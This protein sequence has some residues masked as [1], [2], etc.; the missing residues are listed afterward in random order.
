MTFSP[1][2][3]IFLESVLLLCSLHIFHPRYK[4]DV[5]YW[6]IHPP[7]K[8]CIIAFAVGCMNPYPKHWVKG[9]RHSKANV[10]RTH[11]C[12]HEIKIASKTWDQNFAHRKTR[13]L[14]SLGNN[15]LATLFRARY[16]GR[17]LQR[18]WTESKKLKKK[19]EKRWCT[20]F[21]NS[22]LIILSFFSYKTKRH[23]NFRRECNWR[24][25]GLELWNIATAQKC[26]MNDRI[27]LRQDESPIVH[28]LGFYQKK[29]RLSQC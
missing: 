3:E 12:K 6:H 17:F 19:L 7:M 18:L 22:A 16:S 1:W 13:Y 4:N 11:L 21:K 25:N 15:I 28:H 8:H 14:T 27:Y 26:L 5:N 23:S 10:S 29:E 20:I 9:N 2:L 24:E